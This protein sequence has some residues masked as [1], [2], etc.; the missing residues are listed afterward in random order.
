[1]VEMTP[2]LL[3]P[4]TETGCQVVIHGQARF[5]LRAHN[6]VRYRAEA[7]PDSAL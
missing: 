2:V 5:R 3:K 1:M 6:Q 4:E 7:W